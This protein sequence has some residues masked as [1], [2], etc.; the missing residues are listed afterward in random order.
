M[1]NYIIAN[2]DRKEYLRPIVFGE[3]GSLESVMKSYEGVMTALIVLL[4]DGNNRGGGDLRSDA[5]VIGTWAGNRI[6]IID[7]AVISAELSEPGMET[8]PLQ[9]QI[10]ALGK[11]ISRDIYDVITEGEPDWTPA[12]LNAQLKLAMSE[13]RELLSLGSNLLLTATGR[14]TPMH[15]LEDLFYAFSVTAGL[16]PYSAAKQMQKGLDRMAVLFA[17]PEKYQVLMVTFS[18]GAKTMRVGR[19]ASERVPG[20]GIVKARILVTSEGRSI[21]KVVNVRFGE[22]GSTL[23]Q[24]YRE[25]FPNIEFE[26]KPS[27]LSNVQSPEVAKLLSMIPNLGA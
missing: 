25:F 8:T 22:N 10:T 1:S 12:K 23:D 4:A 17:Q 13:Q 6:A 21:P 16:T 7:D 2:F 9:Q 18:K 11:D 15:D 20:K 14:S 27:V 19:W 5:E 26:T 3:S 24:V